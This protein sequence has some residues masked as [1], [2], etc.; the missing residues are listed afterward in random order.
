[1]KEKQPI[2]PMADE[3]P[4]L[5]GVF[6]EVY[7]RVAGQP[8]GETARILTAFAASLADGEELT[9]ATFLFSSFSPE[10]RSGITV[11]CIP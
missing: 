8:T 3:R 1:M 5:A 11:R 4:E 2:Y 10:S 9:T 7:Q 6:E